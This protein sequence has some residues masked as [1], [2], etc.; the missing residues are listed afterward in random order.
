MSEEDITWS[1]KVDW[2]NI[3]NIL[4]LDS[5]L[6]ISDLK[7]E[8]ALKKLTKTYTTEI[9]LELEPS[10]LD[11]L[12]ADEL[13]V[14]MKK[15]L[16][17]KARREEKMEKEMRSKVIPLK[18]GGIIKIDPRDFKDLDPNSDP[19]DI[20]EFLYKKFMDK[21]DNDDDD[22]DIHNEDSTGFYI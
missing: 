8:K 9:L 16:M 12:V 21:G 5:I 6:Q 4:N 18:R 17:L 1:V 3:L 19:E 7:R 15:E 13:K 2:L 20:M 14:L 11:A 22:D 10:D